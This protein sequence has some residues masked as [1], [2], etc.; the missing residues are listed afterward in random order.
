MA[1]AKSLIASLVLI[2]EVLPETSVAFLMTYKGT[3]RNLPLK[4]MS[5]NHKLKG[6]GGLKIDACNGQDRRKAGEGFHGSRSGTGSGDGSACCG[7]TDNGRSIKFGARS[8]AETRGV[9]PAED[10][11]GTVASCV[12]R[13][14]EDSRDRVC[15]MSPLLHAIP[16]RTTYFVQSTIQKPKAFFK[17]HTPSSD[18]GRGGVTAGPAA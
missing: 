16:L 17:R 11:A 8:G 7:S 10:G 15:A 1:G 12:R 9:G 14:S 5:T 18:G 13:K 3:V 6:F 2:K 4:Q